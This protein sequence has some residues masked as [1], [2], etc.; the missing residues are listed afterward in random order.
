MTFFEFIALSASL[1]A[2]VAFGGVFV[3]VIVVVVAAQ[4]SIASANDTISKTVQTQKL[5]TA[6]TPLEVHTYN[7]H[8][9]THK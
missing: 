9:L 2:P 6:L 3:V 8:T 4:K 7:T 5:L 1:S